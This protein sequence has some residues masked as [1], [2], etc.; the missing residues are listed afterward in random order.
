M[1]PA[2]ADLCDELGEAARVCPLPWRS[3]GGRSRFAG[4]VRTVWVDRD[5]ALVRT[6]LSE[7]GGGAVL[8]VDGGGAADAALVGDQ[9][10]GLAVANGWAGIVV[11]GVV[12]DAAVLRGLDLGVMALGTFPR[13][14][15]RE[16]AGER[17]VSLRFGGASFAPGDR[18]VVDE[19]GVV[20]TDQASA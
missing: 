19:D 20:V 14:G 12:R 17:D 15:A 3:F 6:M 7:P 4:P 10:A 5:N 1:T 2:T 9:L 8:V 11:H 18:V 13:R 16:G